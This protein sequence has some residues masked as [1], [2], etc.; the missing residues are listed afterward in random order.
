MTKELIKED[1]DKIRENNPNLYRLLKA[2]ATL[3]NEELE[4]ITALINAKV[5]IS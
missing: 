5:R 3:S 1:L 2:A 4:I